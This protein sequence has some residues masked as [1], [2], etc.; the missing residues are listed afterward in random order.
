[1]RNHIFLRSS[2]ESIS[3]PCDGDPAPHSCAVARRMDLRESSCTTTPC[4]IQGLAIAFMAVCRLS[5][6]WLLRCYYQPAIAMPYLGVD[7]MMVQQSDIQ[8][9]RQR[10]WPTLKMTVCI[11][12]SQVSTHFYLAGIFGEGDAMIAMFM[13]CHWTT[14]RPQLSS[15]HVAADLSFITLG[16]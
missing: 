10:P 15:V 3:R 12:N 13:N 2:P 1:M 16:G 4:V 6:Q 9:F 7:A 5:T 14:A 11:F 8:S